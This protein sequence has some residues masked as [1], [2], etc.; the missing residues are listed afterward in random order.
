MKDRRFRGQE[1]KLAMRL[2]IYGNGD[3]QVVTCHMTFCRQCIAAGVRKNWTL[4][5]SQVFLPTLVAKPVRRRERAARTHVI[6]SVTR[7]RV[8]H[9]RPWAQRSIAFVGSTNQQRDV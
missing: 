3:A 1:V 2:A 5:F 8:R 6:P 4:D 7:V 9:A